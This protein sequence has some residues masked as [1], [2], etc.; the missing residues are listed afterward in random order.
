MP[1]LDFPEIAGGWIPPHLDFREIAGSRSR[2][3]WGF[4]EIAGRSFIPFLDFREIAGVGELHAAARPVGRPPLAHDVDDRGIHPPTADRVAG[5]RAMLEP[6][7]THGH[8][9]LR[10]VGVSMGWNDDIDAAPIVQQRLHLVHGARTAFSRQRSAFS[11]ASA[12]RG[13]NGGACGPAICGPHGAEPRFAGLTAE[14]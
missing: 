4:P 9:E 1:S 12:A 10:E 13:A 6:G 2:A 8:L 14:S 3:L 11:S 5:Q 7:S